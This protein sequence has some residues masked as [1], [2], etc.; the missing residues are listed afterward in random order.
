MKNKEYNSGKKNICS[1]PKVSLSFKSK[2]P[3]I[4]YD[5]HDL[6]LLSQCQ[7]FVTNKN[8]IYNRTFQTNFMYI[9]RILKNPIYIDYI[10]NL[11]IVNI[12]NIINS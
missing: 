6:E 12:V 2:Y 3:K 1:E 4:R 8:K 10:I 5:S 9:Y 11:Y 7:T